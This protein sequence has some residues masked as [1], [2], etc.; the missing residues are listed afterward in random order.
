MKFKVSPH[1][2]LIRFRALFRMSVF[3]LVSCFFRKRLRLWW[4]NQSN[5]QLPRHQKRQNRKFFY[6]ICSND[7]AKTAPPKTPK[8]SHQT[9]MSTL[10]GTTS[11]LET[12]FDKF[13]LPI[14]FEK[15]LRARQRGKNQSKITNYAK[16]TQFSICPNSCKRSYD[17][18]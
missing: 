14:R 2:P 4:K 6:P 9:R 18:D 17:N 5:T 12:F 3:V 10:T 15:P 11:V 16:Q 1:T 13:I 8:F 7:L